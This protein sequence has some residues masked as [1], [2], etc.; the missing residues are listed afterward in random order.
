VASPVA[1]LRPPPSAADGLDRACHPAIVCH[2]E[3][4][5]KER[6]KCTQVAMLALATTIALTAIDTYKPNGYAMSSH[7]V[8]REG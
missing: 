7:V 3:F 1:C 8:G 6:L 5:G 2:Q 4:D